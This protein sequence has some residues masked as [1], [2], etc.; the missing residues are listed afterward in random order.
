MQY[1]LLAVPGCVPIVTT[2]VMLVANVAR[3]QKRTLPMPSLTVVDV[4]FS[5]VFLR[6]RLARSRLNSK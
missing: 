4:T 1:D 2:T 5:K 3:P 6:P